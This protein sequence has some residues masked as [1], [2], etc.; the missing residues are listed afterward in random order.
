MT[1]IKII[2]DHT[3]LDGL[4]YQL[5]IAEGGLPNTAKAMDDG[6]KKIQSVWQAYALGAKML[7]NVMP[8]KNPS[9]KYA[10]SIKTQQIGPFSHE[11]YSEAKI[12]DRIENGTEELDMKETHT[13]GPRS[14]ISNDG[15]PYVIIPFRWGTPGDKKNPRVGF[16]NNVMTAG[17]YYQISKKSFKASTVTASPVNSD[18]Q[19]PNAK[20]EMVGRG[21]Y[22]WGSRLQGSDFKGT[23]Q[24][25]TRMDGMVR[26]ENGYDKNGKIDKRYGGY[27]TFRVISAKSPKDSWIKPATPARNVTRGV[28]EYTEDEITLMAKEGLEED[29]RL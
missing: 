26:F 24:Q 2:M 10:E 17:A 3:K 29:F 12:A 9:G 1:S 15:I 23:D 11:I 25:K 18:Y 5:R 16:G 8:L 21:K 20:G 19:T 13:R 6:A 4:L 28:K 14:R 22:Q 7:P 27:F